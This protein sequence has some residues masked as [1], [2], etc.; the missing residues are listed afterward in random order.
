MIAQLILKSITLLENIGIY[1]DGIICDGATT[2]R[3]MWKEFGIDGSKAN[4]KYYFQH[5]IYPDRNV[6][7]LSDFVHLFKCIRN[8]LYNSKH[9]RVN[10]IFLN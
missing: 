5:P 1:V 3:R 4:L 7:V 6:Y 10:I 2:K 9:L 8:R